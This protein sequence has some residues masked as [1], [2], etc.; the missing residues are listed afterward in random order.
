MK[1]STKGRY[2]L[3]ATIDLAVHSDGKP[4]LLRDIASR[5]GLSRRYLERLFASLKSAGV[6]RS[7]RGALGGYML[8]K[9]PHD[10]KVADILEALEGPFVPVDCVADDSICQ[11]ADGC[12]AR[13]IWCDVSIHL[14]TFF[15]GIALQTLIDRYRSRQNQGA[16]DY[17]I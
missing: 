2:G 6:I 8:A 12:I 3:R 4:I 11:Q 1:I 5:Q 13:D 17:Q 16:M 15:D 9:D 10:I 14:K 7:V